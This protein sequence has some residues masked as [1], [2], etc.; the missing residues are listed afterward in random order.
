MPFLFLGLLCELLAFIFG[1][2]GWKTTPGKIAAIG[3][4]CMGLLII[5]GFLLLGFLSFRAVQVPV[6]ESYDTPAAVAI[7]H[8]EYPLDTLEDLI[9]Q[10]MA[11]L[12]EEFYV[13]GEASL[14]FVSDSSEKKT[15]RLYE[16]KPTDIESGILI[17]QAQLKSLDLKGQAYLEMWCNIPGRGEFFSRD[18]EQ[19]IAGT[20][21]WIHAQT[22]FRLEFGQIPANVKLN[23]VIEGPGTVWIDDI[24]LLSSPLN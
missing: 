5:P 12:D 10:D 8:Q 11:T 6:P 22:P 21:D 15:I 20:T 13:N 17:Y 23:L 19:P 18:L 3:V 2:I 16:V 4:P 9:S 14:K 7:I 24:K 1:I